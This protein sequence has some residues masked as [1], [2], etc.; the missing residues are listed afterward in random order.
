MVREPGGERWL[1]SIDDVHSR[2][3]P[4]GG[5][6]LLTAVTRSL[7]VVLVAFAL[8]A[9]QS[10][11]AAATAVKQSAMIIDANTGEVLYDQGGDEPR[12]PASL[13]KMMTLYMLFGEIEAGRLS[14]DSTIKISARANSMAPSKL[15]LEVGEEISV[16]DAIR[17]LVIKS[18]ND[19]AVAVAE[20]IG[21]SE[22][23]FASMMTERAHQIGMRNTNFRNASGLP[24]PNQ[25]TTA[26]D[27]VTLA[28]RLQ[29]DYPQQYKMFSI[30][31]F[32]FRGKVH[33]THNTLM[34][35]FPGMD[36][37][38]TGY[39]RA[40]GFNLV[41]SVNANGRHVVGAVFGGK[42]AAT[43][44][45]H[46][47]SLL[48]AA[49]EK[50]ST[51]R[52]RPSSQKLIA[53]QRRAAPAAQAMD[54]AWAAETSEAP[55]AKPAKKA[56]ALKTAAKQAPSAIPAPVPAPRPA[57]QSINEVLAEQGDAEDGAAPEQEASV[58][59][60]LDLQALRAAMSE[61]RSEPEDGAPAAPPAQAAAT[62]APVDIAGLIRNS[63]VDGVPVDKRGTAAAARA[64]ATLDSQAH[65]LAATETGTASDS[66]GYLNG[67][68]YTAPIGAGFEIQ[69][70]AFGTAEEAQAKL[71]SVRGRASA[72][73]DGH[74]G[75]TMPA[76]KADRQFFRARFVSFD[77]GSAN[78]TCLEL[79]RMAVD[80]FVMRAD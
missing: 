79:R 52:T 48:F 64:P 58:S 80:C 42:T 66:P 30:T 27:M 53:V 13:T 73:L 41:S 22:Y 36:G 45:A 40:S 47:R 18:A 5:R 43:R 57:K 6:S 71:D 67:G 20:H 78:S 59:P 29:D 50:A 77:E 4:T 16:N 44:N 34:L 7:F 25:V 75:V 74:G 10:A 28:L 1:F 39:T 61:P 32:T 37:I 24:N 14:Y 11:R 76:Q 2:V 12:F 31:S 26:R 35:R 19:I 38:K 65:A 68:G 23:Q 70:G 21:G 69:I 3:N 63:I 60:R 72:L 33:K 9:P 55:A 49:I 15:G 17:A 8:A 51:E 46:M 56:A 54:M 62:A